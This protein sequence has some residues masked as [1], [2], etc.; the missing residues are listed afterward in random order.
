LFKLPKFLST[1]LIVL[2]GYDQSQQ[3]LFVYMLDSLDYLILGE[4]LEQRIRSLDC[5]AHLSNIIH[6]D[7]DQAQVVVCL[8]VAL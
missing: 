2:S 6:E 4:C 7:N 3:M 1:S 8:K 5:N